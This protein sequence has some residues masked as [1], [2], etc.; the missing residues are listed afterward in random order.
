MIFSLQL[1]QK[2][3]GFCTFLLDFLTSSLLAML[4]VWAKG[5][6]LSFNVDSKLVFWF[7]FGFSFGTTVVLIESGIEGEQLKL[8]R[9]HY[10]NQTQIDTGKSLSEALIL[11]SINPLY[12]N[13]LFIELQ[14]K[15]KFS[16]CCVH[17]LF[18]MSNQNQNQFVYTTC[19]GLVFFL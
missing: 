19:A 8:G 1:L 9:G 5:A 4:L 10:Q 7:P 6:R 14:E 11:A 17:K 12:D 16:T 18:W 3:F 13:R 2:F 15:Y